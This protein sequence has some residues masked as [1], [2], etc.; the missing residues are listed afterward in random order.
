MPLDCLT[1]LEHRIYTPVAEEACDCWPSASRKMSDGVW[2]PGSVDPHEES[3]MS[4][5]PLDLDLERR[6]PKVVGMCQQVGLRH[7]LPSWLGEGRGD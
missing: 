1:S 2:M 5:N 4:R 7:A 3:E 6:V